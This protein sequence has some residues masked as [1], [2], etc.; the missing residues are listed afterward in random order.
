VTYAT[1]LVNLEA[2]RSNA[3][4]LAVA[5]QVAER[6][7][8]G[9]IGYTACA[10][11]Q[12]IYGDGY[13]YGNVLEQDSTEIEQE[14]TIAEAEFRDAFG[15]QPRF[16]DWRP[17]ILATSLSDH[18]AKEA[19]RAD[20]ILTNADGPGPLNVARQVDLGALVMQAG[21]PVLL[22][23]PG[24]TPFSMHRILIGWKNTREARR[25]VTDAMPMLKAARHVDIVEVAA[26]EDLSAVRARLDDV[27]GW[28]G[29]HGVAA[30]VHAR[31]AVDDDAWFDTIAS[32]LAADVVVAGAY[33]HSRVREWALGGVT[34]SLLRHPVRSALVSH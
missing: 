25:A 14:T 3:H 29:R 26:R 34:R 6:F 19:C 30:D 20:L 27:A 7:G 2:G 22:V 18:L 23:A 4:L 5:R 8:A 13:A 16:L 9:V 15:N 33:G 24:V 32:E 12:L 11:I 21:R 17:S 10:P 31:L 28:L 1:I